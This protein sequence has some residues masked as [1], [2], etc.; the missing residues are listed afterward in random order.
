[1]VALA[2]AGALASTGT[3]Y[4]GARNLL[5]GQAQRARNVIPKAWDIPPRADGV[6]GQ[7][8]GPVQR[9]ERGTPVDVHLMIFGDSTA[10]GYG[11]RSADE[12]PGVLIARGLAEQTG[13]RIRLST[14]AINRGHLQGLVRPGRRHVRGRSATGRRGHPDRCQRRH[15]AQRHRRLRAQARRSGATAVRQRRGGR[16]RHLPRLR[17]RQGDPAAAAL[18]GAHPRTAARPRTVRRRQG[19]R[20]RAGAAGLAWSTRSSGIRPS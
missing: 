12:V 17:C 2:A 19:G 14:K 4:L 9:W 7:G 10:T 11:C 5:I 16:R 18:D 15:R 3:A 20:R 1:M 13:K 8:G 6:Y